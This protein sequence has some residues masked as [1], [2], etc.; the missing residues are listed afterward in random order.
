MSRTRENCVTHQLG[1]GY[2]ID[3]GIAN[4]GAPSKCVPLEALTIDTMIHIVEYEGAKRHVGG[5][6]GR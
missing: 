2:G 6:Q 1:V 5:R 3:F 4:E